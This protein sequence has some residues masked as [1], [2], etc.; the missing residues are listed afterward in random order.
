MSYY[1]ELDRNDQDIT[2]EDEATE[3]GLN[4]QTIDELEGFIEE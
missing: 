2:Q 3:Q 4:I 1:D